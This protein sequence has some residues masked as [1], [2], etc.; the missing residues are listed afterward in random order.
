LSLLQDNSERPA[1][2]WAVFQT[3]IS[4]IMVMAVCYVWSHSSST[5]FVPAYGSTNPA[6]SSYITH[7]DDAFGAFGVIQLPQPS[8]KECF[9]D[10]L[11]LTDETINK[12]KVFFALKKMTNEK[13]LIMLIG[14]LGRHECG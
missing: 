11:P 9:Y 7:F 5:Y 14:N 10:F 8:I 2:H 4:R 12:D 3:N 6:K 1:G 13:M